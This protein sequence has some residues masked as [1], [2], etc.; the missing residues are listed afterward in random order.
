MSEIHSTT[1]HSHPE[2]HYSCDLAR[3]PPELRRQL[4]ELDLDGE[5][6]AF[7][8]DARRQ[9]HG[10][11]TA[12][13]HGLLRGFLSDFDVNG[14]LGTYP[15]FL[16]SRAQWQ[17]LLGSTKVARLLDVGAGS[18]DV[19]ERLAPL[20]ARVETTETSSMMARRLRQRGFECRRADAAELELGAEF[21]LVTCLN[22]IDRSPRPRSLL[23]A[24]ARGLAPGGRL[25]VATPLPYA[26]FVYAG[27]TTRPPLERLPVSS[28]D[29]E[30]GAT[31]L[32]LRVLAPLGLEVV[33]LTRAPYLSGGDPAEPLYVL[34]DVVVVC[35]KRSA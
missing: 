2:L 28:P 26:P 8:E 23:A 12:A 34:D 29:F 24:L 1:E 33:A 14:L 20:A 16:L 19:T 27:G 6:L 35:R 5:T 7:I 9:R 4:V 22:V 31:E 18:G 11:V 10:R 30:G 13:L 32:A 21:D 25:V 17:R 15:L 3:L